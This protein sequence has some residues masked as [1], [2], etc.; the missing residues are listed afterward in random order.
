MIVHLRKSSFK[1]KFGGQRCHGSQECISR[2][3]DTVHTSFFTFQ[4]LC[5]KRKV[6]YHYHIV[7]V[8][9]P[10]ASKELA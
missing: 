7:C 8:R 3:I 10:K 5:F 9:E 6:K 2:I 4:D 1:W